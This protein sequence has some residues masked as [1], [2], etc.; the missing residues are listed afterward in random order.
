MRA[1]LK[2]NPHKNCHR[3]KKS[4]VARSGISLL[5]SKSIPWLLRVYIGPVFN[6]Y[7]TLLWY[8]QDEK[9]MKRL[10]FETSASCPQIS[11]PFWAFWHSIFKREKQNKV[12]QRTCSNGRDLSLVHCGSYLA[13]TN[14]AT[15]RWWKRCCVSR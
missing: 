5:F 3:K 7:M 11:F 9:L 15:R 1:S 8:H 13:T 10:I 12:R 6:L 4:G 2:K 14:V